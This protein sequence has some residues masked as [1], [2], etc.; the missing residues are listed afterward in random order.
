MFMSLEN[1]L[2][3]VKKS[4]RNILATSI[5]A[6]SLSSGAEP[7]KIEVSGEEWDYSQSV[8]STAQSMTGG[9]ASNW[10]RSKD[11]INS[12]AYVSGRVTEDGLEIAYSSTNPKN[13]SSNDLQ[14]NANESRVFVYVP[15]GTKINVLGKEIAAYKSGE[16][17]QRELT[18]IDNSNGA[19]MRVGRN[20][21]DNLK[22]MDP[23]K[24]AIKS[25]SGG[26]LSMGLVDEFYNWTER[27][28]KKSIAD[29]SI[30]ENM[31]KKQVDVVR[32]DLGVMDKSDA[33]MLREMA[34]KI[35]MTF[36]SDS[37]KI[38]VSV[39]YRVAVKQSE[40]NYDDRGVCEMYTSPVLVPAKKKS[41]SSESGGFF[42]GVWIT[43]KTFMDRPYGIVF[44]GNEIFSVSFEGD[45]EDKL[46][47]KSPQ[48]NKTEVVVPK[49][50]TRNGG[51][52]DLEKISDDEFIF[53]QFDGHNRE[54]IVFKK[55]DSYLKKI[56]RE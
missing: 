54:K 56:D 40:N 3:C 5:L 42:E 53:N 15:E 34:R 50:W 7:H 49:D 20:L 8:Q 24:N 27:E 37:E 21:I 26:L 52:I 9:A 14:L 2:S 18:D 12:T 39:L 31:L 46:T 51:S 23:S 33:T 32:I 38:P 19:I 22:E 35:R 36:E 13:P 11:K 55:L 30:F 25:L 10:L 28:S 16:M 4:I 17:I 43:D 1:K 29:Q 44:F 47:L 48:Q 6:Y 45:F 41:S